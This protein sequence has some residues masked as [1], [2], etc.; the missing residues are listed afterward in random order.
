MLSWLPPL[1]DV[2]IAVDEA[3]CGRAGM[4]GIQSAAGGSS[5]EEGVHQELEWEGGT[6]PWSSLRFNKIV[7]VGF[8]IVWCVLIRKLYNLC[9]LIMCGGFVIYREYRWCYDYDAYVNLYLYQ[10]KKKMN[11]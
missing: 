5:V 1:V 9:M 2:M 4:D 8:C 11:L 7:M 10:K 3:V 6:S